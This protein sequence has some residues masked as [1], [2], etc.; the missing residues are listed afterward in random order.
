[1]SHIAKDMFHCRNHDPALFSFMTYHPV[2][3][4]INTHLK[5]NLMMLGVNVLVFF[6]F[7]DYFE[8]FPSFQYLILQD[9]FFFIYLLVLLCIMGFLDFFLLTEIV[10]FTRTSVIEGCC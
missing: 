3:N 4:K 7:N 5:I 6:C 1:V 8:E 9:V 10:V 2:C